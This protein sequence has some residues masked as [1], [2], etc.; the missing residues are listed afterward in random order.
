MLTETSRGRP[1][2]CRGDVSLLWPATP[3]PFHLPI[4]S[5]FGFQLHTGNSFPCRRSASSHSKT[6][7]SGVA[8]RPA[9]IPCTHGLQPMRPG[10]PRPRFRPWNYHKTKL[11]RQHSLDQ[12]LE[13]DFNLSFLGS[14]IGRKR[15]PCPS[16]STVIMGCLG[17]ELK[18]QS[19]KPRFPFYLCGTRRSS[20]TFPG[21]RKGN[22]RSRKA[23]RRH[24]FGEL[25]GS[26]HDH[27]C[28]WFWADQAGGHPSF[29]G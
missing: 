3:L 12:S 26:L 20:K 17:R 4:V 27:W 8:R 13:K 22:S 5:W 29:Q 11:K 1:G 16:R 9:P 10:T 19:T 25:H 2:T 28:A 14:Q 18:F 21:A 6:R 23:W 15:E 24:E 7:S